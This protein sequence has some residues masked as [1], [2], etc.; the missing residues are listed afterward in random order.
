MFRSGLTGEVS[1]PR[2]K[3][4]R[5]VVETRPATYYNGHEGQDDVIT[6]VGTE[7]AKEV[8]ARL[9]EVDPE[10]A[11]RLAAAERPSTLILEATAYAAH[12]HAKK[13]KKAFDDCAMCQ[14]NVKFFASLP[15][16]FLTKVTEEK[17]FR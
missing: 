14:D 3:L 12:A 2:E 15:L 8:N 5:M 11:A 6:T 7:I 9:S 4:V 13:C 16:H 10:K 17:R 1:E